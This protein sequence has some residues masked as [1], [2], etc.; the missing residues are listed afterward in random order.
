MPTCLSIPFATGRCTRKGYAASVRRQSHQRL[1][2][3]SSFPNGWIGGKYPASTAADLFRGFLTSHAA[4]RQHDAVHAQQDEI[5]ADRQ[6][7][8]NGR[9][10]GVQQHER[11]QHDA[12]DIQN[13]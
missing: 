10:H 5:E 8:G 3:I 2:N 7:H 6:A 1:R 13:E 12:E 4:E 11:C 9:Q